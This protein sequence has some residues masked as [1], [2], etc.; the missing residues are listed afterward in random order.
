MKHLMILFCAL[1]IS[2]CDSKISAVSSNVNQSVAA[3]AVGMTGDFVSDNL[4]KDGLTFH[5]DWTVSLTTSGAE[6]A[7]KSYKI[8]GNRLTIESIPFPFEIEKNGSLSN[9][10]AAFGNYSKK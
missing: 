1:F 6:W 3:P 8:E 9:K 2:A 10:A 4:P 5:P 7:R